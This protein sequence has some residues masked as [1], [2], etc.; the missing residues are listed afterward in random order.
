[1]K[2][3]TGPRSGWNRCRQAANLLM[4]LILALPLLVT[5]EEDV[6][7]LIN[8]QQLNRQESPSTKATLYL[9]RLIEQRTGH[10]IKVTVHP[11][12]L[13]N[14]QTKNLQPAAIQ[15][16]VT[17][18]DQLSNNTAQQFSPNMQRLDDHT[19]NSYQLLIDRDFWAHLSPELK[20]ILQGAAKD[21][22]NYFSELERKN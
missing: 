12:T 15:M 10:R 16:T 5:A 6:P 8:L 2:A 3:D 4:F 18:T 21:T 19:D 7:I 1:M 14:E 17:D 11:S 22:I 13:D 9:K 20:I